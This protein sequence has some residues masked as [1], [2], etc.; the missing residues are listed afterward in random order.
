MLTSKFGSKSQVEAMIQ[1]EEIVLLPFGDIRGFDTTGMNAIVYV[2]EAQNL[3]KELLK[4]GIQR[5]GSDSKMIIDGDYNAQ[6][7]SRAYEG[8]NNGMR[9]AS[10]VFRGV[11]YYGEVELPII[12]RSE[13]AKRAE[14]M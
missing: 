10:E 14:L 6:V 11:E 9:R 3:D 4:L 12:Y 5:L 7:D 1:R 13:M 8:S 2:I